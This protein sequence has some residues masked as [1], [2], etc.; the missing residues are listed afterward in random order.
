M[1]ASTPSL[2]RTTPPDEND[3]AAAD[4][5]DDSYQH[6]RQVHCFSDTDLKLLCRHCSGR[7]CSPAA[8]RQETVLRPGTLTATTTTTSIIVRH[9]RSSGRRAPNP[10]GAGKLGSLTLPLMLVALMEALHS[11]TLYFSDSL[12]QSYI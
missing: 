9:E 2:S 6:Q 7:R 5:D 10:S 11:L 12:R 4:D 3:N 8:K 1:R